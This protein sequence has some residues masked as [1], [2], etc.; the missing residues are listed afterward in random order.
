MQITRTNPF[1]GKTNTREIDVTYDQLDRWQGG[2]LIQ[3]AMPHL[4]ADDREFIKT[5][6]DNWDEM[7]DVSPESLADAYGLI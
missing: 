1:T 7:F 4:S 3:V 2:E 6:I 5:G